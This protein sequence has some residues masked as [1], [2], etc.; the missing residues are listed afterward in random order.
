[1]PVL[2]SPD[3]MAA[4]AQPS[5]SPRVAIVTGGSRGIGRQTVGRP[6]ADGYAVAVGCAGNRD[7]A[8]A[9]VNRPA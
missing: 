4:P 8:E 7:E 9:A 3:G 5:A 6:A 2:P 1:M